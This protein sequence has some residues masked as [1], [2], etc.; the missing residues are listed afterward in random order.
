MMVTATLEGKKIVAL[1]DSGATGIY[2][3]EKWVNKHGIPTVSLEQ[4]VGI[5][6]ADESMPESIKIRKTTK[7]LQLKVKGRRN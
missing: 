4:P 6:L 3:S 2:L 7:T 5:R 1:V